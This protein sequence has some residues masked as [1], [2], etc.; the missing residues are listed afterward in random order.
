[1]EMKKNVKLIISI[2]LVIITTLILI[3]NVVAVED[4][5]SWDPNAN[6]ESG[7]RFLAKAGIVL[8][9]IKYLGILIAV[10]ALAFIGI[11]YMF[12]SI[13][14]KADYKKAMLPYILG[15]FMLVGISIVIGLIENI[16]VPSE[17][18]PKNEI[19]KPEK[20]V[21]PGTPILMPY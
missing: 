11:K 5:E 14:G 15:C 3:N 6:I 18:T 8:G 7:T 4:P 20:P 19:S 21:T 10:L 13:E 1:M 9:W 17:T 2:A 12:T 16:A